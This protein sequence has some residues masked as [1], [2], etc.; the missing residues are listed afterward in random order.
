[1]HTTSLALSSTQLENYQ[2]PTEIQPEMLH[3]DVTFI[4]SIEDKSTHRCL[5]CKAAAELNSESL[6]KCSSCEHLMHVKKINN[7]HRRR[8]PNYSFGRHLRN[9]RSL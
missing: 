5:V 3:E 9:T 4:A 7:A 6:Y 8:G 2:Q 1:M